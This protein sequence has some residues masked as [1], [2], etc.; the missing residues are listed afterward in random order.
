MENHIVKKK[1]VSFYTFLKCI[2]H[3]LAYY[4]TIPIFVICILLKKKKKKIYRLQEE[5]IVFNKTEKYVQKLV[6]YI[7]I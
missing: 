6:F 2:S 4:K 1:I 7:Y 5:V 3:D